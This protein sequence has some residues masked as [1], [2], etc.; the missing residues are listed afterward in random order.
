MA[1]R[2]VLSV[3]HN[4]PR[5]RPG[6]A[7][8][9][10][11]EL[12]LALRERE[13]WD[14]VFV[15]RSGRPHSP[16]GR[17]HV[18]TALSPVSG[19]DDEY[20]LYPEGYD[21][22]WLF[23][24][25]RHTKELYTRDLRELLLALRP[26][27]VHFQHTLFL[28]YDAIRE[29][30]ETLPQAAIVYTLHEFLPICHH[31]GQMVRTRTHALCAE[32][33]PSR[34][35][36]CFPEISPQAFFLRKRFIQAQLRHVD[37]FLAPSAVLRD[38]FVE[39]GIRPE[40]ILLEDYGRRGLGDRRAGGRPEP[41]D[42]LGYFGQL[43]PFK[44]VDVLLA[45]MRLSEVAG[46]AKPRLRVHGANLDLADRGY[47]ARLEGLLEASGDRVEFAGPYVGDDLDGR[48]G[49]V[50]WV[51]VPSIWWENSPLVIQEAFARGRPVICS[52]V[53]GMAEKVNDGI[54]GLHFERGDAESL[55]ATI[56]RAV[57]TPGLWDQLRRGI[58]PPP[59]MD[60]HLDVL[61]EAYERLLARRAA[62]PVG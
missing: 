14:S 17:P 49:D 41:H 4:H 60:R 36:E 19:T 7:E 3:C 28:G 21:F 24:S 10:A 22:D 23:G 51:V 59:A 43:N 12:H 15:A 9:Y 26:D 61:T 16:G 58:P 55:A 39:W 54:N 6:G 45:A 31:K 29:A 5:V 32:E 62:V 18:T 37:L 53:G 48:M 1:Q 35:N 33:S 34:C 42:R 46:A 20:L 40:R 38:R 13:G 2:R 8:T 30:R 57:S 11:H 44:G 52:D 47:R 27:V 25:I 50:D 56:E